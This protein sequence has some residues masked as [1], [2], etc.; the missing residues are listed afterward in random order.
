M[1]QALHI[2]TAV[3]TPVDLTAT[4]ASLPEVTVA[5]V[6]DSVPARNQ[7]QT[8]PM[9][10]TNVLDSSFLEKLPSVAEMVAE[11]KASGLL[12]PAL[13]MTVASETAIQENDNPNKEPPSATTD[14]HDQVIET[15]ALMLANTATVF[16]RPRAE[17]LLETEPEGFKL[18]WTAI[19]AL[20]G[21]IIMFFALWLAYRQM[22]SNGLNNQEILDTTM[23]IISSQ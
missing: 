12:D 8:A 14:F 19:L 6:V 13:G 23:Q 22:R 9:V 18:S 21:I 11:L 2:D 3:I 17:Q 16:E 5:G 20:I 10:A 1:Y 15:P 4:S 7:T